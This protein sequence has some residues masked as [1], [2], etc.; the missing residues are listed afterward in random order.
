MEDVFFASLGE[1]IDGR[2]GSCGPYATDPD[3]RRNVAGGNGAGR[4]LRRRVPLRRGVHEDLLPAVLHGSSAAAP[5]RAFFRRRRRSHGPRLSPVQTVPPGP[6][7]LRPP[8]GAG[9]T[10]ERPSEPI[11]PRGEEGRSGGEPQTSRPALRAVRGVHQSPLRRPNDGGTSRRAARKHRKERAGRG[12]RVRESPSSFYR[13]FRERWNA[14]P[15]EF[16]ETQR[17]EK[18]CSSKERRP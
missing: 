1:N 5:E 10:G 7:G 3:G 4:G 15:R 16:R 17:R 11:P 13:H 18:T 14:T 8:T 9:G 2:R 12:P 6:P